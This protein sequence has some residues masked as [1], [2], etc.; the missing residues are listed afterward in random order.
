MSFRL[1]IM[2]VMHAQTTTCIVTIGMCMNLVKGVPTLAFV[3]KSYSLMCVVC[4][5]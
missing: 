2:F 1:V 3:H 4:M 5:Y